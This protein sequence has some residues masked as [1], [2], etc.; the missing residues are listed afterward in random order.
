MA[1]SRSVMPSSTGEDGT[2][3]NKSPI[4]KAIDKILQEL[5]PNS[6][7]SANRAKNQRDLQKEVAKLQMVLGSL[8]EGGERKRPSRSGRGK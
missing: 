4:R 8:V 3:S 5:D 2:D 7:T 6:E 1:V